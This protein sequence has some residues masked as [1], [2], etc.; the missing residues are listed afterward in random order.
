MFGQAEDYRGDQIRRV[1]EVIIVFIS[2][3]YKL[4]NLFIFSPVAK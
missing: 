4:L 2:N 3:F 1:Y